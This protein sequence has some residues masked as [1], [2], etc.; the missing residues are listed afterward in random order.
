MGAAPEQYHDAALGDEVRASGERMPQRHACATIDGVCLSDELDL[1]R[2]AQPRV[3]RPPELEALGSSDTDIFDGASTTSSA[4]TGRTDLL[5]LSPASPQ[6]QQSSDLQNVPLQFARS[7]IVSHGPMP[8]P[9]SQEPPAQSAPQE[10][11]EAQAA[12]LSVRRLP[13]RMMTSGMSPGPKSTASG[14]GN[15]KLPRAVPRGYSASSYSPN[16]S[17]LSETDTSLETVLMRQRSL[18][19]EDGAIGELD[20]GVAED[21]AHG[22]PEKVLPNMVGLVEL[23]EMGA[24]GLH[25]G[26]HG[27]M[28]PSTDARRTSD[29]AVTDDDQFSLSSSAAQS[30]PVCRTDM[31]RQRARM[32][33]REHTRQL[34]MRRALSNI[35]ASASVATYSSQPLL[36][37]PSGKKSRI[38]GRLPMGRGSLGGGTTNAPRGS[39]ED[40][41]RDAMASGDPDRVW[42]SLESYLDSKTTDE[43][44]QRIKAALTTFTTEFFYARHH[45]RPRAVQ[46]QWLLRREMIPAYSS[47][48]DIAFGI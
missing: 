47:T 22:E 33:S 26:E 34:E 40:G 45:E 43:Q 1:V 18:S 32:Q 39:S 21:V 16:W 23:A 9:A 13:P 6:Q 20:I 48:E 38:I 37:S 35:D 12:R 4:S 11:P 25:G 27:D 5:E 14:S 46:M 7:V 3:P 17:A 36:S 2:D 41:L 8:Q 19:G 29:G 28:P 24:E 42:S 10:P 30:S 31:L 15:M 44:R